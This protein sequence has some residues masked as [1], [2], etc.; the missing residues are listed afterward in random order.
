MTRSTIILSTALLLFLPA[1]LAAQSEIE[2]TVPARPDGLVT[3]TNV[4]GSVVVTGWDR[5]EVEITGTLGRGVEELDIESG[6]RSV[7]IEVELVHRSRGR[8]ANADLEIRVPRGSELDIEV[9]SAEVEI[10]EVTGEVTIES[11]S[12]AVDVEGQPKELDVE[13]VSGS[14]EI[15]AETEKVTIESVSGG[16]HLA[17]TMR[18][19]E[20]ATVSG[21]IEIET[22]ELR[23][24]ELETTSGGVEIFG[25]LAAGAEVDVESHSGSV[26]LGLP[27]STSA[28]FEVA[29]FSGRITNVLGP[30]PD[31]NRYGPGK[32]LDFEVGGGSA[33]VKI[34]TFSGSVTLRL[35]D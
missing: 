12:G 28:R 5:D 10:M 16:I 3:I 33:R 2:R 13:S 11:V 26:D 17:G 9:V 25:S 34:D 6:G 15:D 18:E 22:G 8:D 29:T 4:A 31:R 35:R 7:E 21:R 14:I 27:S 19:I 24:A 30:P 1:A 23:S 20:A 32:E